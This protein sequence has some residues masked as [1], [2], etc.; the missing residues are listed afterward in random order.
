MNINLKLLLIAAIYPTIMLIK[1]LHKAKADTKVD[2]ATGK[3]PCKSCRRMILPVTAER[4]E[5]YCGVC[6]KNN[7]E[8][9]IDRGLKWVKCTKCGCETRP[10]TIEKNGGLC[11]RCARSK[12]I[13]EDIKSN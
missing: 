9:D 13:A 1:D 5:G 8:N 11:M 3:I 4:T 2:I 12:K 10:A 6:D 7:R